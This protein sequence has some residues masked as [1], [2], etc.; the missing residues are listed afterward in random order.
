M[1]GGTCGVGVESWNTGKYRHPC[2]RTYPDGLN[3]PEETKEDKGDS[4]FLKTEAEDSFYNS[5]SK[6]CYI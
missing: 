2:G 3:S 6:L 1:V 4:Q 5:L